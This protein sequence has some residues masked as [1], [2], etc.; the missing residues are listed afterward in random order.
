MDELDDREL[1]AAL[2][3][4]ADELTA[5]VV[6]TEAALDV[7]RHRGR[8]RRRWRAATAGVL[9][10]AAASVGVLAVTS[11][12]GDDQVVRTPATSPVVDT[13]TL[14]P[15]A[16]PTTLAPSTTSPSTTEVTAPTLV[17]Y[18]STGGSITVRLAG[19]AIT[20]AEDPV[21]APGFSVRIDED[22]P[23]R[24]RVRF[25]RDEQRSE[26]R[27]ELENGVP[28]PEIIED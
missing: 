15:T 1:A 3:G 13:T 21:A 22:G 6:D 25:E 14:P 8:S 24:V 9:A 18:D 7:V 23:D 5:G 16:P 10:A 28:V 17:T 19:G 26:I 12:T 4:R 27:V 2:R 11:V 20:L